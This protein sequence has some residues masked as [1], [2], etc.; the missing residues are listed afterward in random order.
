MSGNINLNNIDELEA[1]VEV[2]LLLMIENNAKNIDELT[3]IL[4][5]KSAAGE[6]PSKNSIKKDEEAAAEDSEKNKF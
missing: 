6:Y 3:E 4:D 1:A 2:L 5:K